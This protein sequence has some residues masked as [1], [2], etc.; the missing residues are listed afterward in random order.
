MMVGLVF[1]LCETTHG[2]LV[3]LFASTNFIVLIYLSLIIN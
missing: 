1:R 3:V 2:R